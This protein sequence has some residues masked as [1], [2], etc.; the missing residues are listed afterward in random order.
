MGTKLKLSGSWHALM[1]PTWQVYFS[2][3]VRI[4]FYDLLNY[5]NEDCGDVSCKIS[6]YFCCL[7][8]ETFFTTKY[9][10]LLSEW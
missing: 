2:F 7:A 8:E 4:E 3:I 1:S 10:V 6:F 9:G 5:G